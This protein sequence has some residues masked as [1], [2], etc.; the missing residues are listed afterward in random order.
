MSKFK[1]RIFIRA[2][3]PT[4]THGKWR[5]RAERN[6][7][8]TTTLNILHRE[9]RDKYPNCGG[10]IHGPYGDGR[11]RLQFYGDI[12]FNLAAEI[13]WFETEKGKRYAKL[14]V[15]DEIK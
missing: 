15:R 12:A 13:G 9:I 6:S 1:N 10:K 3:A 7:T 14:M 2:I 5:L 4:H 11:Y 8:N